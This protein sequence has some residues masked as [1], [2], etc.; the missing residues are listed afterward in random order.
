MQSSITGG[1]VG[2]AVGGGIFGSLKAE[3]GDKWS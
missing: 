3:A 2:G 1:S